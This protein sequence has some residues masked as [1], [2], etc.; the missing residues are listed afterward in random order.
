[1]QSFICQTCELEID[2]PDSSLL[3]VEN[4]GCP[5]QWTSVPVAVI[6]PPKPIKSAGLASKL[7]AVEAHL[8]P[9][10]V[11]K[12]R[13]VTGKTFTLVVGVVSMFREKIPALWTELAQRLGFEPKPT[14][15]QA[16]VWEA[17]AQSSNAR[18]IQFTA[19]NK[20]IVR[21]FESKWRWVTKILSEHGVSFAFS[22][23]HSMGFAA[24]RKAFPRISMDEYRVMNLIATTLGKDVRELRRTKF[25]MLKGVERLVGLCKMNL[26]DGTDVNDL[27]GLV[28]HHDIDLDK[29]TNEVFTLVPTILDKC[30]HPE[31]DGLID[32]DDMIWLPIARSLIVPKNDVLLIDE[33]QD[34]NRCQQGLAKLAGHRLILVG[35][36]KQAIYGFAG[37]D[38]E[39]MPRML[40]ELSATKAGCLELPLTFTRRCGKAIVLEANKL[41]PD[42]AAFPENGEGKVS[43]ANYPTFESAGTRKERPFEQTYLARVHDGDMVLCRVNAPLVSQCFRFLKRGIKANIQGRD[44]GQGLRSTIEKLG[45]ADVQDLTRK[46]GDWLSNET[47]KERAKKFPSDGRIIALQDRH[48]CLLAFCEEAK[49]ISEVLRKIEVIFTDDRS[50]QGIRLSSIHKAKGLEAKTVF[51]LQPKGATIPHPMAKTAWQHEQELNLLYVATTRAIE[52]FVN[53]F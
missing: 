9:H 50:R 29:Y 31:E 53:V 37:A 3:P 8:K 51:L 52:E 33:C 7:K 34:L 30:K 4:Y 21:E 20:S 43:E 26:I 10:I 42:F 41:V 23:N 19:F 39:S 49:E 5:H 11:V 46:I 36:E 22:T 17:M 28:A 25:E 35:D 12:A 47:S 18:T 2:S 44:V 38:T 45:S 16:Q 1:M 27:Q 13:A 48:D 24:V 6:P 32:Y 15:Q 14:E 40:R